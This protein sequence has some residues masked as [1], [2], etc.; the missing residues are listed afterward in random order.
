VNGDAAAAQELQRV[1]YEIKT[2]TQR[3]K[4]LEGARTPEKIIFL[5][6]NAAKVGHVEM[7]EGNVLVELLSGNNPFIKQIGSRRRMLALPWTRHGA[8]GREN[9][10]AKS[11][12]GTREKFTSG[13][14]ANSALAGAQHSALF[15]CLAYGAK[16]PDPAVDLTVG[17]IIESL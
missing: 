6:L 5:G 7:T 11:G 8:V 10:T 14:K 4:M 15:E 9:V 17:G 13:R 2:G 1:G 12:E 16:L 3:S